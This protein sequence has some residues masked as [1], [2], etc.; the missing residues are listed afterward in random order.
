MQAGLVALPARPFP[1]TCVLHIG[2]VLAIAMNGNVLVHVFAETFHQK[3]KRGCLWQDSRAAKQQLSLCEVTGRGGGGGGWSIKGV[4]WCGVVSCCVRWYGVVWC[5]VLCCAVLC[6]SEG[7][8]P[9]R[10]WLG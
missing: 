3:H 2:Y 10:Q 1:V 8:V 5:G 9:K 7:A 4:V 6:C